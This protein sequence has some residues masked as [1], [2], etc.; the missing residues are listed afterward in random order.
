MP[1]AG[2]GARG[3]R[4]SDPPQVLALF[5]PTATGKSAIAHALARELGGEVV[6]ADPFQRYR[7]LEIA[8]DAPRAGRREE[9]PHHLVGDLSLSDDSTAGEY[10]AHAHRVVDDV[11]ARGGLPVVAGGTGLYLRAALCA[12]DMRPPPPAAVRAWAE[13]LADD[14]AAALA[15]LEVRD[16]G[17]AMTV[18]AANPRR[19]ARA[20]ERAATGEG[21]TGHDIWAAP[22]RRPTLL[23]LVD[24]PRE[25]LNALI[26]QRVRRE[27]GEGLREEL[28]AALDTR[29][30][31]RGPAQV[32]GMAEVRAIRAGTLDPDALEEALCVRTRRLARM[33]RT[34]MRRMH[35]DLLLDLGDGPPEAAVPEIT[36]LVRRRREGVV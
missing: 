13:D 17:A 34:W 14:P 24:R 26:A 7:G 5:G 18:D 30:L 31:A 2:A 21:A 1:G 3:G 27:L 4:L 16:P 12:L 11:S 28:E 10:A 22:Y 35:P 15:E 19:L 29:G 32:I 33:Q 23:V 20:L 8:S 9:V 25:V 6:V 36:A